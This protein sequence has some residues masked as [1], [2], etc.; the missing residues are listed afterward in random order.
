MAEALEAEGIELIHVIGPGT[1]HAYHP[2]SQREVERR[3]DSLAA[4]G[5]RRYPDVVDFTTYTLKYNRMCWV[6]VD[7]LG[8]ALGAG[9][10]RAEVGGR[11][12]SKSSRP[13]TS[14]ALP[15]IFPPDGA[16][17]ESM[18]AGH[19]HIDGPSSRARARSP[20]A[21]GAARFDDGGAMG[22]RGSH[23][24][25]ATQAARPPG[26]DRRRFHGLVRLRPADRRRA[27]T[28]A[29]REWG[30]RRFRH[31]IEHWRRQFRG[32]AGVKDDTAIDDEDIA[33]RTSSSGATPAATPSCARIADR[34]PIRWDGG[35]IKARDR[36]VRAGPARPGPDLP[37]PAQPA[38]A[39]SYSTAASLT[40][41]TT[42]STTPAR[43]PSFPTGRSSTSRRPPTRGTPARSSR[44]TSS[45]RTGS[46]ARRRRDVEATLRLRPIGS[47]MSRVPT[48]ARCC[49]RGA[50]SGRPCG[51]ASTGRGC[52]AGCLRRYL[53]CR[54][55]WIVPPP[56]PARRI[57][58]S[59]WLWRLPSPI[60]L[61]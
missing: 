30:E 32:E 46:S 24:R 37:E 11:S 55:V 25:L 19:D 52:S 18:P 15:S 9:P 28:R 27:P 61:P 47:F 35:R 53:M 40:A 6:T 3:L 22:R 50:R 48:G 4:R 33:G 20:T 7:A 2:D 14:K 51:R 16:R 44:P 57:G 17:F 29:F 60:P 23:R 42:T 43:C 56:R 12:A 36:V 26:A 58:R 13:R 1:K 34:L 59:L 38:T 31:A 39:T 10:V 41:S 21:R 45:A 5:R 49:R 54:P 8:D